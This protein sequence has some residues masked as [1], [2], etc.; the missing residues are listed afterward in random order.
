MSFA[1]VAANATVII[2][3]I[4]ATAAVAGVAMSADASRQSSNMAKD[5]AKVNAQAADQ[6]INRANQK[7]PDS[8]AAMAANVL[9]G[10]AGQSGT[11]LTGSQGIDQSQLTLGKTNLLGG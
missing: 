11:M 5:A 8:A 4:G 3:G 10:K 1:W 2:A 9:A 6:A 7:S